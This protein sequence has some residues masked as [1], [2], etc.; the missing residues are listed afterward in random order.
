MVSSEGR[1]V[2]LGWGLD[3]P[4]VASLVLGEGARGKT[5]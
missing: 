3:L 4:R 5:L 1:E 2:G